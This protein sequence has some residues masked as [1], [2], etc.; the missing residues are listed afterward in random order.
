MTID[1]RTTKQKQRDA[2]WQQI[3]GDYMELS[4]LAPEASANRRMVSVAD[5]HKMTTA[6]VRNVLLK[7][8]IISTK[9]SR[10]AEK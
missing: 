2:R 9:K 5:K 10:R 8:G 3:V 4:K 6:G 7:C 1:L